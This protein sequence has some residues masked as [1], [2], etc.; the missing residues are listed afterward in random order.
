M[1]RLIIVRHG[2][3]K[4][5]ELHRFAGQ[6][7]VPL[8][9][10]GEK[11]ADAVTEFLKNEHIDVVYSSDLQRAYN[12]VRGSAE[13]RGLHIIKDKNLREIY[14]GDW[15]YQYY[16]YIE[17]NYNKQW[18]LWR[19]DM[20]RCEPENGESVMA[21]RDRIKAEIEKIA[22][23]NDGKTVLIGTHATPIRIMETVWKGLPFEEI[24]NLEWVKN[25]SVTITEYEKDLTFRL[26]EL[27]RYD[28]LGDKA[29]WFPK[30]I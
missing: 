2:Q 26:I 1:T 22:L 24:K 5:N 17:E 12:T 10:L 19:E 3:S 8:T 6:T 20:S 21:L 11:Q 4:G 30:N 28:F 18:K 23:E 16:D 14:V 13:L 9:E 7:D 25:A 29:T 15:E 27:G